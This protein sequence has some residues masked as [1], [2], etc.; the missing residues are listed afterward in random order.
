MGVVRTTTAALTVV[1]LIGCSEPPRPMCG[2]GLLEG[3]ELC[4][5]G[6]VTRGDGCSPSCDYDGEYSSCGNGILE[7][8]EACDDGNDVDDDGCTND[9]ALAACGD[10]IVQAGELCDDGNRVNDDACSNRCGPPHLCG[11]GEVNRGEEC[12][13]G[14][15]SNDDGCVPYCASARCGDGFVHVGVEE[16]DDGNDDDHD[17][18]TTACTFSARCGDGVVDPGELC[19]DGNDDDTDACRNTCVHA[20]CG[21]GVVWA[22]D[23]AC[24][25]GPFATT[26]PGCVRDG[27]VGDGRIDLG[28]ECDDGNASNTDACLETLTRAV[29]GDGYVWEGVELCDDG[30]TDDADGCTTRCAPP[31]CGDGVVQA[32]ELC[33]DGDV[34]DT[35]GC[36]SACVPAVCGDG[37]VQAGEECDDALVSA[38]DSCLDD[39]TLARC[40]DGVVLEGVEGC[41]DDEGFCS[42]TCERR[43]DAADWPGFVEAAMGPDGRCYLTSRELATWPTARD[44]CRAIGA[45]LVSVE[46][47]E[48]GER[49]R[50]QVVAAGAHTTWTGL[51]RQET[52]WR[53]IDESPILFLDWSPAEPDGRG[54]AGEDCVAMDTDP[55]S[56]TFGRWSDE[57]CDTFRAYTC[58]YAWPSPWGDR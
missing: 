54:S 22:G 46:S 2:D 36:T 17:G 25:D 24:D 4:D 47:P 35:D 32:P 20:V 53:Q 29:C 23:E 56:P 48:L 10:G 13:D 26:C 50:D 57:G 19:D 9:C 5:D 6:N 12:D 18:C 33:D 58:E 38:V 30:N 27:D 34:D 39:C 45:E 43:C 42:E 15:A 31:T 16:C 44:A 55:T 8:G 49:V 28:E 1:A 21:D 51:H 52:T 37:H 11:N 41:D 14:N 3:D 7:I 40:G